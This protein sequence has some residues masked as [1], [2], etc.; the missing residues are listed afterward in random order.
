MEEAG[1]NGKRGSV[2]AGKERRILHKCA[3]RSGNNMWCGYGGPLDRFARLEDFCLVCTRK[4]GQAG[5]C[6]AGR[7]AVVVESC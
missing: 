5:V 1:F 3:V 4:Q 2:L 6:V 7:G